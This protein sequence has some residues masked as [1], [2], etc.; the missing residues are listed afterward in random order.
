MNA[1]KLAEKDAY[2]FMEA[3]HLIDE[4]DIKIGKI[5]NYAKEFTKKVE[6]LDVKTNKPHQRDMNKL[7]TALDKATK[8]KHI[9]LK[10]A[11]IAGVAFVAYSQGWDLK[12]RARLK[13]S[14]IQY[15]H[16]RGRGEY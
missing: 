16:N 2:R 11:A 5:P 12:A 10:I 9:P 4:I 1:S 8:S 7:G 3:I 14:Y 6:K 13:Q 15:K